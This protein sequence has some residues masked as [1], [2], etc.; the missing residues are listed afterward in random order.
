MPGGVRAAGEKAT[1]ELTSRKLETRE[2][3]MLL[4]YTE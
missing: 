3:E 4:H 1:H 2:P